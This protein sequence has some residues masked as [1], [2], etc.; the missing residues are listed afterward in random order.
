LAIG[1]AT[2]FALGFLAGAQIVTDDDT[3]VG[4]VTSTQRAA[5]STTEPRKRRRIERPFLVRPVEIFEATDAQAEHRWQEQ[6]SKEV[7]DVLR[8]KLKLERL[9][10]P[11]Q[12]PEAVATPVFLYMQGLM[13]GLIRAAPDLVDGLAA[14]IE[15]SVCNPDASQEE[16]IGLSYITRLAPELANSRSFECIFSIHARGEENA[17]LWY[18]L[19]AWKASGLP[20]TESLVAIERTAKDPRTRERFSTAEHIPPTPDHD[21]G[22]APHPLGPMVAVP[23]S[24]E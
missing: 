19:D 10:F 17:V 3:S 21:A 14:S 18:A 12:S 4:D 7:L 24:P 15:A 20:K 6:Q 5:E 23:A 1:A 13:D 8:S 11:E 2:I 16:I 9:Q 22:M